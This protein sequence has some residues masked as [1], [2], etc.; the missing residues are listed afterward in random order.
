MVGDAPALAIDVDDSLGKG[1]WSLLRQIVPDAALDEPVRILAR[2]L[3]GIGSW[4]PD[5]AHHW[6][7]LRA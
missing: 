5:A 7:R 3:L 4:R 1:L 2:E 6:H